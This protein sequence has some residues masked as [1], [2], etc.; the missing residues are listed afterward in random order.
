[1][2]YKYW[3][4]KKC[5]LTLNGLTLVMLNNRLNNLIYD[6][7]YE[8]LTNFSMYVFTSRDEKV[9]VLISWEA[10]KQVTKFI[11]NASHM[12]VCTHAY[13]RPPPLPPTIYCYGRNV[14][15]WHYQWPKCPWPKCPRRNVR[16]RNV[17]AEMSVAEMP[18]HR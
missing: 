18:E 16:G 9:S 1:M 17:R 5:Y 4:M 3:A 10:S 11:L 12:Y 2:F 15:L 8:C 13:S 7:I 6:T 14:H